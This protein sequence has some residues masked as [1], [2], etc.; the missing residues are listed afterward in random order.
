MFTFF[1]QQYIGDS[2]SIHDVGDSPTTLSFTKDHVDWV[3]GDPGANSILHLVVY[4]LL[5]HSHR[6]MICVFQP[7]DISEIQRS[8]LLRFHLGG[9][10]I[11]LNWPDLSLPSVQIL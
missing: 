11:G 1:T 8:G 5:L 4:A 9:I 3:M 10:V 6:V 2:V 7:S